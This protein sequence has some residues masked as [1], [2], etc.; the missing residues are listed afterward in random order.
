MC[1]LTTACLI[2]HQLQKKATFQPN[3]CS[4][5]AA[6]LLWELLSLRVSEVPPA[7]FTIK[8]KYD[9]GNA[10]WCS[11]RVHILC[12]T[13]SWPPVVPTMG[14]TALPQARSKPGLG[15][16]SSASA[17][18]LCESLCCQAFFKAHQNAKP[19]ALG[20]HSGFLCQIQCNPCISLPR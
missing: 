17:K 9:K 8:G 1:F 11:V 19:E 12:L 13:A 18:I 3:K 15:L 14:T 2:L 10:V 5:S 16:S 4:R 20:F 7:T 6:L